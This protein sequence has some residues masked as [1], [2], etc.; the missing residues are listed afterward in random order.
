MFYLN[1][2]LNDK[3]PPLSNKLP[4]IGQACYG[5]LKQ[6]HAQI[7]GSEYILSILCSVNRTNN[8]LK[9]Y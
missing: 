9:S 5:T 8:A 4:D 6:S 3:G 1:N 2:T 7:K